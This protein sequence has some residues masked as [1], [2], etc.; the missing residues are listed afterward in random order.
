M[1]LVV[2]NDYEAMFQKAAA[3]A[4][5]AI[6]KDRESLISFPGKL[7]KEPINRGFLH[8]HAKNPQVQQASSGLNSGTFRLSPGAYLR[9]ATP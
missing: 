6:K 4:A 3:L 5:E 2:Y 7:P 1:T 8:E 9:Q